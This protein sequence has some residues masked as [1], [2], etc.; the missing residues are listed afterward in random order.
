MEL[1]IDHVSKQYRDKIAV[2][3]FSAELSVGVYALLGP[4]GSGK[5]TL[6]RMLA[7]LL[8]PSTGRILLNHRDITVMDGEYRDILGLSLIHI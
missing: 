8:K 7:G 1:T 4:N 3:Q 2:N 5:T 6:M